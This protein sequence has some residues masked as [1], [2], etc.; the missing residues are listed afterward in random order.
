MHCTL[1]IPF[2]SK[3]SIQTIVQWQR[4]RSFAFPPSSQGFVAWLSLPQPLWVANGNCQGLC[5]CEYFSGENSAKKENTAQEN[6][7][8][9]CTIHRDHGE[10][11]WQPDLDQD[12]VQQTHFYR[13][14][15]SGTL[16][17]GQKGW[18][19]TAAGYWFNFW[20]NSADDSNKYAAAN[21]TFQLGRFDFSHD[22]V[23]V[24]CCDGTGWPNRKFA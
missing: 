20:F 2:F 4:K 11:G 5:K 15:T 8:K 14:W 1:A 9:F 22:G 17:K 12:R 6:R 16:S 3:L 23:E 13:F 7:L 21:A 24:V 10:G 18:D 19:Q